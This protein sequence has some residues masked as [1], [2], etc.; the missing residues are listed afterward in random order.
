MRWVDSIFVLRANQLRD[1]DS[2]YYVMVRNEAPNS[3][4]TDNDWPKQALR[5]TNSVDSELQ[6]RR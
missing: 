2:V 5:R 4:A 1:L 3:K 6:K